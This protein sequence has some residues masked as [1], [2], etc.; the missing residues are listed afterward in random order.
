L[1]QKPWLLRIMGHSS[2]MKL[3]QLQRVAQDRAI[4]M[5]AIGL[6]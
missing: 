6:I 3:L 5:A 2:L 4:V 1:R